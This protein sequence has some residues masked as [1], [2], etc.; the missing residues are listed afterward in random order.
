MQTTEVNKL[1]T[2]VE[3]IK[4]NKIYE[5]AFEWRFE[6]PEVLN[7]DGDFVGFDVVIGNP[8]YVF[9]RE[10]FD[11][12]TKKYFYDNYKTIDYQVNLYVLFI[13]RSLN[14]LNHKGDYSLI[15]PNSFLMVSSTTK[16]R[17]CLMKTSQLTEVVNF[18][19]ESFD[20]VNVETITIAGTKNTLKSNDIQI[21]IGTNSQINNSHLKKQSFFKSN[22]DY[23]LNVFSKKE[24]DDLTKKLIMDS[25]LLDNIVYIKAGLKAYQKGKGKPKQTEEDVKNRPFDY[26]YKFDESTFQYL[27]GKNIN[28]FS[29]N[30]QGS[31]LKFGEHLAEPRMFRGKKIILREITSKYPKSL[32]ASYTEEDYL[33]NM[34]NIAILPKLLEIDLRYILALISSKLLSYFF[35]K[36]TA[37]SV[38]KMF[39]KI[40]L[41]DLRK[42]PIKVRKINEQQPFIDL[43]DQIIFIKKQDSKS[44]TTIFEDQIDQLVYQL[45]GLT[46]EEIKIV[47]GEV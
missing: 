28:R 8:P 18:M 19:G 17:E 10:N 47:E 15:V 4:S 42:F 27:D 3:E 38:R 14:V 33:F 23:S 13:E 41:N 21:S 31:Y 11:D 1:E 9:A 5:N 34:S 16:S 7:N 46:E 44:D 43:I 20:G 39:P 29:I 35:I 25:V 24:S 45:Y 22:S 30:W 36:N 26:N 32:I 37:K 2:E 12:S 40:I 6:F